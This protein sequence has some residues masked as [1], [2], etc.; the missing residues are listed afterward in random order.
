[1]K[2]KMRKVKRFIDENRY[3]ITIVVVGTAANMAC[4]KIHT[5]KISNGHHQ[6]IEN[7]RVDLPSGIKYVLSD[8]PVESPIVGFTGIHERGLKAKHLGKLGKKIIE[9]GVSKNTRF[10]HFIL[11]GE[12]K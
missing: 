1:M 6:D 3:V 12:K 8:V 10:T 5:N 2:E 7:A 11:I 9:E 4:R